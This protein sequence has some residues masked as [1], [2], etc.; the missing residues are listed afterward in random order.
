MITFAT[1]KKTIVRMATTGNVIIQDVKIVRT[2]RVLIAVI[3][4]AKPTPMTAPTKVWV[5]ETGSCILEHTST[6][7]IAPMSAATPREGVITVIF[8]PTVCITR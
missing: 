4:L 3:P 5:V 7:I 8:V 6:V 2:V 1:R